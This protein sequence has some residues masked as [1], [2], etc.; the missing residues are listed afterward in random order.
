MK[1]SMSRTLVSACCFCVLALSWLSLP[2]ASARHVDTKAAPDFAQID[3][4]VRAQM[5]D[6]RIPGLA[7]AITHGD[8][9]AHL[10]GF[11]AADSA[12]RAVTPQTPFLLGSTTKSFTAVAIMQLVEAGKIELDAP[13]QRYLPW[14]RVADPVASAHISVR[15]LLTQ[16]S[17]LSTS[18]GLQLFTDSP[19]ETPEQ[20]VR[21]LSAVTLTTPVGATYQYSNANYAILGLIVQVV[22]GTSFETYLQEHV[23]NPLQMKQSF[24]SQ[25]QAKRA[26]L[27]QGHRSWFGFPVPIDVPSHPAAFAA[28]YLISSAEDMAH[29]LIAQ[30]NGGRYNGVSLLSPQG[31]DTMHTFAP[32]SSYAMGWGKFSQN[33]ETVLYHDGEIINSHSEMFLAPAQHWGIVLLLNE[34]AGIGAVSPLL[35]YRAII[36]KQILRM[37]EGQPLAPARWSANI[38]YYILDAILALLF[39]LVLVNAMLLPRWYKRFQQPMRYRGIR[40]G[41]RLLGEL[42]LPLLILIGLPALGGYSWPF[43]LLVVPDLGWWILVTMSLLLITGVLRGALV[44]S[45]LGRHKIDAVQP[46]PLP[47]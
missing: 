32:G 7:L 29:Y 12:G 10:Q 41:V 16:V 47:A 17:G 39:A 14:F 4:Y 19:D 40:V 5:Q 11:G 26:G 13:V 37:L 24:M 36:G 42:L 34:G 22:S 28:G 15:H 38:I 20:Y 9:I 46:E 25:E 18:V 3:A 30:S 8:Q 43:I 27:A 2:A 45:T 31:I 6:A 1:V 21:N 33:G 44:Y 23:L 35:V